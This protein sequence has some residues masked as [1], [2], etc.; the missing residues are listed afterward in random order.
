M[1]LKIDGLTEHLTRLSLV[2]PKKVF[3]HEFFSDRNLSERLTQEL[4][5]FLKQQGADLKKIKKIE[6]EAGQ[7]GFSRLR[8]YVATV[9][10]LVYSL[11][12]RQKLIL[13]EY[14]NPPNITL[15]KTRG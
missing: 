1:T 9:N 2:T 13:P 14:K 12:L 11:K 3:V 15:K 5:K 10:A 6:L 4:D 7:M 8:S